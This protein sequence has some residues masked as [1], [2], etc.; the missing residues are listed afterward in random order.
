M[1]K[2][3][4]T[5]LLAFAFFY[6]DQNRLLAQTQRAEDRF[7]IF[8]QQK[9]LTT[10]GDPEML[11]YR[12]P[13][14]IPFQTKGPFTAY[15]LVWH[16]KDGMPAQRLFISFS[17]DGSQWGE[18]QSIVPDGHAENVDGQLI[19]ELYFIQP[20]FRFYR[21]YAPIWE[22]IDNITM[23]FFDPGH[24]DLKATEQSPDIN[25]RAACP[26]PQPSYMGRADWCPSGN[27]PP[28]ATPEYTNATHLIIHHAAGVNTA[29]DW[30]AVVRS[31]WDYHVNS[32][33]WDDVGYNWLIDPNG[34]LYEGRGDG[35]L[36]AHFCGTNGG[37]V[38]VCMLGDF[39]TITPTYSAIDK[40]NSLYS[41]KAC[42]NGIDPLGTSFHASSGKNLHNISGHRDGTCS[43]SCP[44][45]AFY[46]LLP[47]VRTAIQDR[48]ENV[49]F[50]VSSADENFDNEAVTVYPNPTD[51]KLT[52]TVNSNM[53]GQ[54]EMGLV[55]AF[56]RRVGEWLIFDKNSPSQN[57]ELD[58]DGLSA[59]LYWLKIAHPEGTGSYKI[60]KL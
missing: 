38:G 18:L 27:C 1:K 32:N 11:G 12:S 10:E 49:C 54:M 47:Q 43:T 25:D 24:S 42:D 60:I 20:E 31:I 52:V 5:L 56:G 13:R 53:T 44:G 39:T 22:G 33:G 14:P 58:L 17:K 28:D 7:T 36:G 55:D 15:S 4:F 34:V 48:I 3:P 41:W 19:S 37:T 59:G 16:Q 57:F 50:G 46:P 21:L 8:H 40:L 30:A 2:L 51:G 26:C 23:H 35:R 45:D 6:F 9:D 29:S